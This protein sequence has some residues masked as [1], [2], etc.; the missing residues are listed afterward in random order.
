[1]VRRAP[2]HAARRAAPKHRAEQR[3]RRRS[4]RTSARAVVGATSKRPRRTTVAGEADEHERGAVVE[5]ALALH[6]RGEAVR[7]AD[8][9]EREQHAHGV[10]DRRGA[11]RA[12]ARP[13]TAARARTWRSPPCRASEMATPGTASARIGRLARRRLSASAKSAP[14]KTSTGRNATRTTLGL[15][16]RL[17]EDIHEHEEQ[18]DDDQRDVVR[19]ARCASRRWPPPRRR[20]GRAASVRSGP[21][22][23]LLSR[24]DRGPPRGEHRARAGA[25]CHPEDPR[26]IDASRPSRDDLGALDS[27][28]DFLRQSPRGVFMRR[29][30]SR[31][32]GSLSHGPRCH[33]GRLRRG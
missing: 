25:Q 23:W 11:R 21:H 22:Q 15:H 3:R 12:A 13:R 4:P 2:Q 17:G 20:R 19:D 5:E 9:A 26:E 7:H 28:R 18:A 33:R 29:R 32:P 6:D 1:M 8:A 10:G 16:R 27:A 24:A 14:S 30:S 31:G